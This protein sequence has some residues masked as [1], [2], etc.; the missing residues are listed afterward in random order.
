MKRTRRRDRG[1]A[2]DRHQSMRDHTA[3]QDLVAAHAGSSMSGAP[4]SAALHWGGQVVGFVVI[5]SSRS[6]LG[7]NSSSS[8]TWQRIWRQQRRFRLRHRRQRRPSHPRSCAS[9]AGTDISSLSTGGGAGGPY[10][11]N[12]PS[13]PTSRNNSLLIYASRE[14]YKTVERAIYELDRAD[15]G[16]HR[17]R[18]RG[19]VLDEL[20]HGVQFYFQNQTSGARKGIDRIGL[21][22]LARTI[23]AATWCSVRR[24][25]YLVANALSTITD[26]K[27][28]SSPA[29]VV[30]DNQQ[31]MLMSA[32]RCQSRRAPRSTSSSRTRRS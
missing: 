18:R 17:L 30:L 20:Q 14:Q 7:D 8:G 9:C 23:P 16:R 11:L 28:L 27:V 31:A 10:L 15:A 5:A 24:P 29:L 26:V 2:C 21:T 13:P 12:V 1:C 3:N 19:H 25:P 6:T 32:T 22:I 4:A